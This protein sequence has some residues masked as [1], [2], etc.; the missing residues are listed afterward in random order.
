[1]LLILDA[2]ILSVAAVCDGEIIYRNRGFDRDQTRPRPGRR[3][4]QQVESR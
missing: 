2:L 4:R 3:K 1:M